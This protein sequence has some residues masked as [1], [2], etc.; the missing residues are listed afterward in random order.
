MDSILA[1][2]AAAIFFLYFY[3]DLLIRFFFNRK[4]INQ[5]LFVHMSILFFVLLQINNTDPKEYQEMNE[6]NAI[7]NGTTRDT[8]DENRFQV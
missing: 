8:R 2:A 4:K 7:E 1:A 3:S 6:K 5:I